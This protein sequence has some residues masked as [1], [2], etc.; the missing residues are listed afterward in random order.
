MAQSRTPRKQKLAQLGSSQFTCWFSLS[1]FSYLCK[2]MRLQ[3]RREHV[4]VLF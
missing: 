2:N 1:G 3:L 4:A